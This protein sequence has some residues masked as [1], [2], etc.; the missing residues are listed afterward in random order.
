MSEVMLKSINGGTRI[1]T[2]NKSLIE[3]LNNN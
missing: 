3:H 2:Q 1:D